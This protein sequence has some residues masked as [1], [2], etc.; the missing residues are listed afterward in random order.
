MPSVH[1]GPR[2]LCEGEMDQVRSISTGKAVSLCVVETRTLLQRI[3]VSQIYHI[4]ATWYERSSK[5]T[6]RGSEAVVLHI[7]IVDTRRRWA[8]GFTSSAPLLPGGREK[9]TGVRCVGSWVGLSIGLDAL[10]ETKISCL[11]PESNHDS[12]FFQPIA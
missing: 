2:R 12:S 1:C 8:N 11:C 3:C 10:G 6:R 5:Y 9:V 4:K 7:L